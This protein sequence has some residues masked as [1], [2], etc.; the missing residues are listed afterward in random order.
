MQFLDE[1]HDDLY[2][3]EPLEVLL[4]Q[5][6]RLPQGI[7]VPE[8][9][10]DCFHSDE[11]PALFSGYECDWTEPAPHEDAAALLRDGE[12]KRIFLRQHRRHES[13]QAPLV[14]LPATIGMRRFAELT[15]RRPAEMFRNKRLPSESW[16]DRT[17]ARRQY[18]AA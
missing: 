12:G 13:L 11:D 1:D 16:K 10:A 7:R 17:R 9:W 15:K 18:G 4:E 3:S 6:P 8:S 2:D 14:E 5:T